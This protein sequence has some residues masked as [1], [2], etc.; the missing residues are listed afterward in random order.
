[1]YINNT[2]FQCISFSVQQAP[3]SAFVLF[4]KAFSDYWLLVVIVLVLVVLIIVVVVVVDATTA[5]SAAAAAVV[6]GDSSIQRD[7]S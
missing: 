6:V 1:M 5:A 2:A 4:R 3:H 7:E